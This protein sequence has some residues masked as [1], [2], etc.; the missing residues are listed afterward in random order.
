MMDEILAKLGDPGFIVTLLV[1]VGCATTVL[2]GFMPLLQK[3]DMARRMKAVSSERERIRLRERERMAA[4]N[5][6]RLSLRYKTGGM[7]KRLV[8]MLNLD[9]WLNTETAK[10]KLAMAGFRGQG[11]E[12]AFLAYRLAAPIVFFIAGV[13]YIFFISNLQWSFMLKLGASVG[14]A[15]LGIKAPEIFLSNKIGKRQKAMGRAYPNMVD[16]LIICA[17]VRHV[18]RA[19]CTQGQSGNRT[20]KSGTG[21]RD[22]VA[23]CRN[24]IP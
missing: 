10:M 23:G 1:S 15:Y 14:C 13:V 4:V 12:N 19:R 2:L 7:S 22:V 11:A 3:D 6:P 17:E 21:G 18:D 20:R 5:A 9:S 24:V 16:L 8:D